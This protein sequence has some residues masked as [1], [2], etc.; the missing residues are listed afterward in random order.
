[1][2]L[3]APSNGL[4]D[5]ILVTS[6]DPKDCTQIRSDFERQGYSIDSCT[7]VTELVK[8]DL[9]PYCLVLLEL[10]LDI[11]SGLRAIETIKQSTRWSRTPVIVYSSSTKSEVLVEALNAGADDYIIKPFSLRELT[12]RIRAVLRRRG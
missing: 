6:T 2:T 8:V 7:G 11:S 3:K 4:S 12:A 1:M 10:P 5:R 9:S